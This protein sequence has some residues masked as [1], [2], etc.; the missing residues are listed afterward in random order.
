MERW[1]ADSNLS[2]RYPIY[3]RAN[4]GEVFPA[5]VT[6]YSFDYG[7][8][9]AEWGWRDAWVRMGAFDFDE[10]DANELEQI[11]IS[12]GYAYLNVSIIRLFGE[13]APGLSWE[14]I[15]HQFF[16]AQPGVPPYEEQPGD[17][18]PDLTAKIGETFAWALTVGELPE[19]IDDQKTTKDLRA[20]RPDV[21]SLSDHELVDT[22]DEYW[23]K[24]FRHLFGQ[25]LFATYLATLPVGILGL[26]CAALGR[27]EATLDLIGGLGDVDSAEPSY[28]LWEL[29]RRVQDD[30]GLT[31]AFDD[32]T[33]GLLERLQQLGKSSARSFLASLQGFLHEYG[34][35]GPNEWEVRSPTWETRPELALAAIDR[36]R[37]APPSADPAL[38]HAARAD[39]RLTLGASLTEALAA[40]PGTRDQFVA[41]LRA[42]TVW[43]P[44]RERTKSN[45]I[46]LIHEIRILL[47]ELG[48]R[49]VERGVFDDVEDFGFIRR[50]EMV[51]FLENPVAYR[52]AIRQRREEYN[53]LGGLEPPFLFVGEP[54]PLPEWQ[55]RGVAG[56]GR[57]AVGDTLMGVP[58]CPGEAEGIARVV[59]DPADPGRLGPGDILVAPITDPS[60]TPLFVPAAGVVVDVGALQSHAV[61][62]SRELG[63]PCVVSATAATHRIADG[64]RI[65]IDGGTGAVTVLARA[66]P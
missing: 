29:A 9:L 46:R 2:H 56:E 28:A 35:R 26:V 50:A 54:P 66:G 12:G 7:I 19:L 60:W 21:A 14:A 11:G 51:D 16:G 59:L 24:H 65:R 1:I 52:D 4:V 10:F 53:K 25:H 17:R 3:T 42:A 41:A 39:A 45:A 49:M 47:R 61:I 55:Q 64:D 36:M 44:A 27:P 57:L 15:D 38:Q 31:A 34:S 33:A 22:A 62:V 63:I 6:P 43:L 23:T 30:P 18:R 20:C 48:R 58:G 32:G 13:R 8:H 5:P 37:L 40:D